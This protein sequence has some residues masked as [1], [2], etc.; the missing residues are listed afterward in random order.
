MGIYFLASPPACCCGLAVRRLGPAAGAAGRPVHGLAGTA[1]GRQDS[2][3]CWPGASSRRWGWP[4]APSGHWRTRRVSRRAGRHRALA[5]LLLAAGWAQVG[6]TRTAPAARQ[7]M[8]RLARRMLRDPELL[9][10]AML[11]AGLNLLAFSFYA[12]GPF[13]TGPLPW[14]GF[15][16]IGMAVALAGT[17]GALWNRRLPAQ[18]PRG[19]WRWA[20]AAWR[21]AWRRRDWRSGSRPCPASGGPWPRCPSSPATAWP[22][23]TCWGRRC[24]A[25]AT[26]WAGPARCS[27]WAITACW[28]CCWRRRRGCFRLA[29]AAGAGLGGVTLALAGLHRLR[30]RLT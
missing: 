21:S 30:G 3:R 15:G 13:M 9:C 1:P 23:P 18:G 22:S 27:A 29:R 2:R 28:G 10:T 26:A 5:G 4:P 25:T 8:L 20:C 12:A 16:W 11:V 19:G 14:L 17:L 6:E 24:D 7:P